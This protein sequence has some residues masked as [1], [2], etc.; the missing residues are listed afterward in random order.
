MP[1]SGDCFDTHKRAVSQCRIAKRNRLLKVQT[2]IEEAYKKYDDNFLCKKLEKIVPDPGLE[3]VKQDLIS[4]YDYQ[5]NIILEVRKDI[6][7]AQVKTITSTCQNCTVDTPGTLDH[8]LPKSI[9]S[10]FIVNPKNLF[11]CCSTC[12]SYKSTSVI[13]NPKKQFLN[14]YLDELPEVQYLFVEF[15]EAN[16]EL[17]YEF[18]LENKENAVPADLFSKI[19][20]HYD[21]LHLTERFKLKSIQYKSELENTIKNFRKY[22]SIENIISVLKDKNKDEQKA[23]GHNYFKSILE[24][25][26]LDNEQFMSRF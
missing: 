9:Y 6:R 18:Y 25:A 19:E 11:P 10:E 23:Y 5:S 13:N 22:L 20:Y 3:E 17:D 14:L 12:N 21:K 26:F 1:Y 2:R 16:E 4:L 15:K 24:L 7:E 8:I